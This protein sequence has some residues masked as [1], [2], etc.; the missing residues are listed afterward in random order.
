M[1]LSVNQLY[2]DNKIVCCI[3]K[4]HLINISIL[5]NILIKLLFNSYDNN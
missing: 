4:T 2:M 3:F 1:N 5:Y